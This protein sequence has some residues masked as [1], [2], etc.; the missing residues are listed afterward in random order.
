M[1]PKKYALLRQMI[2]R[3]HASS[4]RFLFYIN[5]GPGPVNTEDTVRSHLG[6]SVF[7]DGS[8]DDKILDLVLEFHADEEPLPELDQWAQFKR[9]DT[10]GVTGPTARSAET[11]RH[12]D[13]RGRDRPPHLA[14]H[15]VQLQRKQQWQAGGGF[16]GGML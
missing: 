12:P 3:F 2:A 7:A 16:W 1:L 15:A 10:S 4:G 5:H 9:T 14:P 8:F 13:G 11:L 6:T